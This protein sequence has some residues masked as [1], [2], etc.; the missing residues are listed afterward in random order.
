MT[1]S[2]HWTF[3]FAGLCA[4]LHFFL[5]IAVIQRRAVTGVDL[6]DGGDTTLLRRIRAHG[7]FAETAPMAMLLLALLEVGGLQAKW[8]VLLGSAFIVARIL[9]AMSLLSNNATWSRRGGTILSLKVLFV[10]AVLCLNL[11]WK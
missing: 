9:H 10:Q 3:L 7:N 4:L 1:I 8:L 11:F 6:L 2:I 5:T